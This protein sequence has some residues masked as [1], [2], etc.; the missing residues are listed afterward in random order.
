MIGLIAWKNVWRNKTRSLVVMISICLGIWAG[1]FMMA[2]SWG[3]SKEYVD[4]A[5]HEQI[6][7]IQIHAKEFKK[8]QS[9]NSTIPAISAV[10]KKI[11]NISQVEF[12]AARTLSGGMVASAN[13]GSGV[14]ILGVD[15]ASE[16]KLT[17]I[18]DK[19]IEGDYFP[20]QRSNSVLIGEKLAS[21]LKVGL[22]NK[23]V[24][25]M[26]DKDG[27]MTAAAFRICGIFKTKNTMF[28]ETNLYV[29]RVDLNR[30]LGID[31]EYAHEVAIL[32]KSNDYLQSSKNKIQ[33]LFPGLTVETW[34]NIAPELQFV[35]GSYEQSLYLFI[36]IILLALAFGIVNIMLMA[37]LER[38]RELG[39]LM[40]IGMNRFRIF[41]MIMLETFFLSLI[42]SPIGVLFAYFTITYFGKV[43]IDLSAFARGL[44]A[45]GMSPIIYT[46]LPAYSYFEIVLM[47]FVSAILAA[48]Y[49]SIKAIKLDPVNAIRKI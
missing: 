7:H 37:V 4:M 19:V 27:N 1:T 47:A 29:K 3:M 48:I 41:M 42:A 30:V 45:Y 8:E 31:N 13:T 44:E 36:S 32:L 17:G 46:Q 33:Q 15:P 5:I 25:T 2:F 16:N 21:K 6:S 11:Q 35:I 12:V 26:Q 40:A 34:E 28:D 39:V 10:C 9:V 18:K 38:V 22:R 43:G 24:L 49:P 14:K 20:N 23:I